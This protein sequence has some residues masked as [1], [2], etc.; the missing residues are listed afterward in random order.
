LCKSDTGID[1]AHI[2][3]K[4][5]AATTTI[6]RG[7]TRSVVGAN[8]R[9]SATARCSSDSWI[10]SRSNA[11]GMFPPKQKGLR[12]VPAVTEDS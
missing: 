6:A 8:D 2:A 11:D 3:Q 4:K 7:A 1:R 5:R 12:E 10:A 9:S